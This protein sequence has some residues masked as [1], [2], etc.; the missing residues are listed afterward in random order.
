MGRARGPDREG[1]AGEAVF[2]IRLR[3]VDPMGARLLPEPQ[4]GPQGW[5]AS[6]CRSRSVAPFTLVC[7]ILRITTSRNIGA[8]GHRL[9]QPRC[10]LTL[11]RP[12]YTS[13]H[14]GPGSY[15]ALPHHGAGR[16]PQGS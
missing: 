7:L 8:R 5:R 12:L 6:I 11:V 1:K 14:P 10:N 16:A 2:V 4:L 3:A 13:S 9:G 15:G